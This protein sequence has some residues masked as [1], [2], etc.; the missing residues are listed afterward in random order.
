VNSGLSTPLGRRVF[1][2]AAAAVGGVLC[3][4]AIERLAGPASVLTASL[5]VAFPLAALTGVAKTT[6]A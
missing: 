5:L 3:V 1:E 6:T 4:L 2:P